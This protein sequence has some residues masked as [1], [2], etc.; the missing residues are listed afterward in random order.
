MLLQVRNLLVR[1]G[2]RTILDD[3]SF[4]V[5]PGEIVALLGPNGAGKSTLVKAVAGIVSPSGGEVVFSRLEKT[6]GRFD[7]SADLS[8]LPQDGIGLSGLSVIESILLGRYDRLGLRVTDAELT[9]AHDALAHFG[10]AELAEQRIDTL[11]GGQ[12]QLAGLTQALYRQPKILLLD[13][14]TSALDLYRQISVLDG[15]SQLV[16]R[17]RISIICVLHDL[18]LA[19]RFAERII[20]LKNGRLVADDA[21]GSVMTSEMVERIYNIEADILTGRDGNLHVAPVRA[22]SAGVEALESRP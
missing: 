17:R 20:F 22:A 14:P 13:E 8:Y 6:T 21:C 10:I 3:I 2:G 18:S 5:R 1:L 12:R 4:T 16:S 19:A 11:S 15:L 9:A 7:P